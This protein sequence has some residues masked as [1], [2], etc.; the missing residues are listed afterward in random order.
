ML[1][2]R[3]PITLQRVALTEVGGAD[4]SSGRTPVSALIVGAHAGAPLHIVTD[5]LG[6]KTTTKDRVYRLRYCRGSRP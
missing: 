6:N 3:N 5:N 1:R 2:F 4:G